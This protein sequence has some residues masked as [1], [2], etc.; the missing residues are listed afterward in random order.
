MDAQGCCGGGVRHR[1]LG[2]GESGSAQ[3]PETAALDAVLGAR[4]RQGSD[5]TGERQRNWE[6]VSFKVKHL[7]SAPREAVVFLR[8]LLV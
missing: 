1:G 4:L 6:E 3:T 5:L 8:G 7:N 2:G